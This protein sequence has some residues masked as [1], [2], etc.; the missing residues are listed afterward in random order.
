MVLPFVKAETWLQTLTEEVDLQRITTPLRVEKEELIQVPCRVGG[1]KREISVRQYDITFSFRGTNGRDLKGSGR[2]FIPTKRPRERL[3]IVVSMHYEMDAKASGR[4]L[5]R[6]WATMTPHGERSYV[7]ANLMGHGLNHSA[8]MA[9]LPRRMPFVD[10]RRVILFGASAGGYHALMASSMVFPLTAVCALVPPLN[11]KYNIN[12]LVKNDPLNVNPQ[13]P[14]KPLAPVV[15]AVMIVGTETSKGGRPD[16][17]DWK[18]FSPTFRTD[19]MTFPT[20][21]TYSTADVLVPIQQLSEDLVREPPPGLWPKGYT[22]DMSKL[23]P[24]RSE[25]KTLMSV[26]RPNQYSLRCLRIPRNSPTILRKREEMPPDEAS[27]I[28]RHTVTWSKTKR[29]SIFV[30]DEGYPEPF[31]GHT[32]YHHELQDQ[33]FF[34]YYMSRSTF[35]PEI[36]N[37]EKL[38]QLMRRFSQREEPTGREYFGDES[39]PISRLDHPHIER[40]Y[41]ATGLE[42]YVRSSKQNATRALNLYRQLPAALQVL[43]LDSCSFEE[44]PLSVLLEHR[45]QALEQ[46]GDAMMAAR[47]RKSAG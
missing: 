13:D 39:W 44:D 16:E 45:C 38:A 29:L 37:K 22:F 10:Q 6:G 4:F 47:L 1:R 7:A 36:L 20:L 2:L 19:L 3:P 26:L 34:Q 46:G 28:P 43:D 11:L 12:Y 17:Q 24:N 33:D 40:W 8:C 31:C 15:R 21:I 32:K 14:Q 23:V 18:P 27:R 41:V 35:R 25:R 42:L 9:Q 30:L 5:A